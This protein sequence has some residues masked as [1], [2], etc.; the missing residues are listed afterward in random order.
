MENP[1]NE[2][3][4]PKSPSALTINVQSWATPIIGLIMLVLGLLG[5]YFGRPLLAGTPASPT[6]PTAVS[7]AN[8][9]QA[10][11]TPDADQL[12]RQQQMMQAVVAQT[13]HFQGDPNAPVT[14]IEF[15]DFQ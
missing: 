2:D 14:I 8:P 7:Q 6:A 13:R 4:R 10:A 5:G 12:A 15:G 1:P 11:A 9:P 3:V